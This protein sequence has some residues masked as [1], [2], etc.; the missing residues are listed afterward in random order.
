MAKEVKGWRAPRNWDY[1]GDDLMRKA[2]NAISQSDDGWECPHCGD[3]ETMEAS[4]MATQNVLNLIFSGESVR[5][6]CNY[7]GKEYFVKCHT[8]FSY[9]S[10]VDE[11]F[12][13]E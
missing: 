3:K 2:V 4:E 8:R 11:K 13:G 7:C 9:S 10:C 6:Y 12:E 5:E 1:E